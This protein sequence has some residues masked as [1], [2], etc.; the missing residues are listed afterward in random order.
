[1]L[2]DQTARLEADRKWLAETHAKL[3]DASKRLDEAF[4]ALKAG[5]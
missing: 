5:R 4:I 2:A 3:A 1:M